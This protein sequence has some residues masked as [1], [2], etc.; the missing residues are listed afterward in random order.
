MQ[1]IFILLESLITFGLWFRFLEEVIFNFRLFSL[2]LYQLFWCVCNC[3][4]RPQRINV[5]Y[6]MYFFFYL[7][8]LEMAFWQN[9]ILIPL[10]LFFCSNFTF[11][12]NGSK[13]KEVFFK[14]IFL[15]FK[16]SISKASFDCLQTCSSIKYDL[17]FCLN[18]L[19]IL[20]ILKFNTSFL[21]LYFSML[22][23]IQEQVLLWL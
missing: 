16:K 13:T 8:P 18:N 21:C 5:P 1:Q 15:T 19:Q 23:L 2:N 6:K 9:L 10:N 14:V 22:H 4:G 11:F 3:L 20:D 17:G 12:P 7:I